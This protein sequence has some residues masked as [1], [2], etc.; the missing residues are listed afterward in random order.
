M[1]TSQRIDFNVYCGSN[2]CFQMLV[3]LAAS[4]VS[5]TYF[6]FITFTCI[7]ASRAHIDWHARSTPATLSM[8]HSTLLPK[9]ATTKSNE[10]LSFRQSR[11]KL[12]MFNT[13][14]RTHGRTFEIGFIIRRL[15]RRVD[16]K[17]KVVSVRIRLILIDRYLA[18]L[19]RLRRPRTSR[20]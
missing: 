10:I 7:W 2:I 3:S 14:A 20:R 4:Q 15:C 5:V 19:T 11:S 13:C 8:Q 9:T 1:Y 17:S 12:S 16:L 18:S 6:L